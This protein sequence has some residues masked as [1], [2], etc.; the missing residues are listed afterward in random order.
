MQYYQGSVSLMRPGPFSITS[1]GQANNPCSAVKALRGYLYL[2]RPGPFTW[3][4][5]ANN[6]HSTVQAFRQASVFD[7]TM[8]FVYYLIGPTITIPGLD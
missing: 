3:L 2:M 1:L 5:Q 7:E 8:P 4:D 6:P